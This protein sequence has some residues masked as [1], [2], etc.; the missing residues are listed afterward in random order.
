VPRIVP[1][2]S[3]FHSPDT[4]GVFLT[5]FVTGASEDLT[6]L[7]YRTTNQSAGGVTLTHRF[8]PAW[9]MALGILTV[10]LGLLILLFFRRTAV[11]NITLARSGR[12]T[13]VIMSGEASPRA[14]DYLVALDAHLKSA[15]SAAESSEEWRVLVEPLARKS[16]KDLELLVATVSE[17]LAGQTTTSAGGSGVYL[18]AAEET[19]AHR[20]AEAV[21]EAAETAGLSVRVVLGCWVPSQARWNEV[22]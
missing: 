20:A 8:L 4:P 12:G 11:V 6:S 5:D 16:G 2:S 1:F 13:A 14:R 22:A 10:P 15:K 9:A 3:E 21:S 19:V 7:G 17:E 18:Y